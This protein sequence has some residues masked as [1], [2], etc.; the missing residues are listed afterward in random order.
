[1]ETLLTSTRT[2]T[3]G[4]ACPPSHTRSSQP[5]T[6]TRLTHPCTHTQTYA[7]YPPNTHTLARLAPPKES[8]REPDRDQRIKYS[9]CGTIC[10]FLFD[11]RRQICQSICDFLCWP[12][13]D[14]FANATSVTVC[15]I[16]R[17]ELSNVLDYNL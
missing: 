7:F 2:Q 8:T 15:D 4:Y 14:L 9:H 1:M 3:Y 6:V 11:G 13:Q 12:Q 16:I 17:Y 5:S 10:D